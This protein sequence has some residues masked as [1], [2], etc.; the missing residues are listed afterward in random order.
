MSTSRHAVLH[1]IQQLDSEKDHQHI[2]FLSNCCDFPFDTSR[3]L[4]FALFRTF[5]VPIALFSVLLFFSSEIGA[6]DGT[7]PEKLLT[8]WA[9]M[10][11]IIL[12]APHGGRQSIPGVPVRRGVAV[13]QF[14]AE[15][16]HNTDELASRTAAKLE[17]RLGVKP[18]LIIALFDRKYVDANR[19]TAG[20]FE[21]VQARPCYESYHRALRDAC[22]AVRRDWGRGLLLDIHGQGAE[23]DVVYRGTNNGK[24]VMSLLDQFGEQAITGPASIFG[25]LE[26]KGY[27]VLPPVG[28]LSKEERYTGGYIVQT[29]G[30]H[31]QTGI[32]AIQL[33]IGAN[34]R[35]RSALDRTAADLADAI[36]IFTRKYLPAAK[37]SV[38]AQLYDSPALQSAK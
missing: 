24:T 28:Y 36:V 5:C 31:Q 37:L 34:L 1:A 19:P 2:V 8:V 18:F 4:E 26:K 30:S 7:L 10:L 27:K 35:R 15:R 32:D 21:S 12:S 9:G 16:D 6:Q 38:G 3:S 33:E 20:A 13:A 23:V 25:H 22:M 17:E 29:Y 11:P 14:T